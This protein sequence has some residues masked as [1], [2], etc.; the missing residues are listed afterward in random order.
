MIIGDNDDD[1]VK[2]LSHEQP[3]LFG[4]LIRKLKLPLLG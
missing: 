1:D 2:V 3:R 4:H